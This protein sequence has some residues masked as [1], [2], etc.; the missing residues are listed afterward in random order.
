[1]SNKNMN[2]LREQLLIDRDA[3]SDCLIEQPQLYYD[4]ARGHAESVARRDAL[5]LDVEEVQA[6]V[7]KRIRTDAAFLVV[8]VTEAAIQQQIKLDA[9]VTDLAHRSLQAREE[10]DLWAALREAYQ[11]R[12]FMLRELV[13]LH[14]SERHDVALSNGAGQ[15]PIAADAM[16]EHNMRATADA[17]R[18]FRVRGKAE[19]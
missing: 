17:R 13:A 16:A 2:R 6:E 19:K 15:R 14:V 4:V 12:S 18:Q 8:K 3:L 10:T 5:K 1:M 9:K 7:D 11:Q